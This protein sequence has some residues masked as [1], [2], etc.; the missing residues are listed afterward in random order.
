MSK[1]QQIVHE[2]SSEY[3]LKVEHRGPGIVGM[4]LGYSVIGDG[5]NC[6]IAYNTKCSRYEETQDIKF[7]KECIERYL[8]I[9]KKWKVQFR[10]QALESDFK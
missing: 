10:K 2:L 3:G 5:Y 8:P 6:I 7:V 4:Y 9:I 1:W